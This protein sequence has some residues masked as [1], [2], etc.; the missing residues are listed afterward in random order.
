MTTDRRITCSLFEGM[1][2][3]VTVVRLMARGGPYSGQPDLHR[4]ICCSVADAF[5]LW[6]SDDSMTKR[7]PIWL[8]RVV[9]GEMRDVENKEV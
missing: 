8:S 2:A 3:L 5:G 7:F 4:Y 6:D 1:A 9:E